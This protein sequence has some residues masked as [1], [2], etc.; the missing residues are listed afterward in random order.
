MARRSSAFSHWANAMQI[1]WVMAEAQSVI[2][3]RLM[4]MAGL[5][6]VTPHENTRMVTEKMHAV[7]KGMTDAN[8]AAL[9]GHSPDRIVAAALKPIR[10]KTRANSKRLA[11]RGPKRP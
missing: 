8:R 9:S 2:A 3:M 1:G 11:K 5:W 4:G 6:S 10:E 7:T